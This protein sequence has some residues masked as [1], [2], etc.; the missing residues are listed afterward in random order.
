M[1]AFFDNRAQRLAE[2]LSAVSK[3]LVPLLEYADYLTQ[4]VSEEKD[5]EV[6]CIAALLRVRAAAAKREI[7]ASL[8]A[9]E[10]AA[11]RIIES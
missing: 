8:E 10:Q 5:T 9:L 4:H 2:A 3:P 7:A 11:S 1:D 6:L